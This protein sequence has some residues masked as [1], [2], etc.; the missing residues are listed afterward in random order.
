[1]PR[2]EH[3]SEERLKQAAMDLFSEQGFE[4]TSVVQIAERSGVTTRTFFRYFSD[5]REVLFADSDTL[6]SELVRAVAEAPDVADPLHVV[7]GAL[8][9]FDWAGRGRDVQRRRYAVIAANPELMERELIKN[10]RMADEFAEA[11]RARGVDARPARLAARVGREIFLLA[12]EEW[13]VGGSADLAVIAK[14]VTAL[15]WSMQSPETTTP[16]SR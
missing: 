14:D 13:L 16:P 11:L 1:M 15:L 2:W 7:V 9:T 3:G 12:Y 8:S 6:R 5:K 4:D 10:A